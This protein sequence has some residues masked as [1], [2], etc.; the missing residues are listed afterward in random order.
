MRE[1][2]GHSL[3]GAV[4][5]LCTLDL[6]QQLGSHANPAVAC[7][8]FATPAVGNMALAEH[9][10]RQ[11]WDKHI[12]NYLVPGK[13]AGTCQHW[14]ELSVVLLNCSKPDCLHMTLLYL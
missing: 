10:S 2:A 4:A 11:G 3:G 1:L 13:P 8:G 5:L 7:V 12:T 9:V 6:L 14:A